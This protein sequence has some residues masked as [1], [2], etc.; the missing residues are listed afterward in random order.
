MI[1]VEDNIREAESQ[2]KNKDNYNR[3][4]HSPTETL[5]RHHRKIEKAQTD[6]KKSCRRI[7]DRKVEKNDTLFTTKN[8]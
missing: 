4:E 3:V 5:N 7:K 6:E 8:T 2:L 1:D